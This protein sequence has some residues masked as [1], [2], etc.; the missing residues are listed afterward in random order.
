MMKRRLTVG[1]AAA[2]AMLVS[3]TFAS[4][5]SSSASLVYHGIICQVRSD[6]PGIIC[7]KS[8]G[9]G[10]GIAIGNH[11]V[12]VSDGTV[13]AYVHSQPLGSSAASYH[14]TNAHNL[15]YDGV[16]CST[17]AGS[18]SVICIKSSGYGV[19]ISTTS[20]LVDDVNGRTV[21]QTWQP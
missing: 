19:A 10:Y 8:D 21:F 1:L 3:V 17:S 4:A 6:I 18:S 16:W 2:V 13:S 14:P 5:A 9:T 12:L 20:V 15:Y 7:V 11:I